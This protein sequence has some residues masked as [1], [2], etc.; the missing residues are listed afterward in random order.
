MSVVKQRNKRQKSQYSK[1]YWKVYNVWLDIRKTPGFDEPPG[2]FSK[3]MI[4]EDVK[5]QVKGQA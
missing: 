5:R 2:E 1:T 4:R 3:R